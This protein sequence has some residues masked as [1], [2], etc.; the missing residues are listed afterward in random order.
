FLFGLGAL[1]KTLVI[2]LLPMIGL[3]WLVAW[4][5]GGLVNTLRPIGAL[6]IAFV[7]VV[8]PWIIR[9]SQVQGTFTLISTNDGRNLHQG[10]NPC[11]ADFLL[12]GWD[13]QWVNC[14]A[15]TPSGL[16]ETQESAW[17]RDQAI[18]YLR[19]HVGEWPRLFGVKFLNLW[20]PDLMPRSVPPVAI[21]DNSAV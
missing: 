15:P 21:M 20:S 18:S 10:N 8:T 17:H 4:R 9:N 12:A 5:R 14:L 6:G 13:A 3:W 7:I 2:L 19:D 11:V 1:T 16:S